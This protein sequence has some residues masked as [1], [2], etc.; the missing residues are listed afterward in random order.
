MELTHGAGVDKIV[1]ASVAQTPDPSMIVVPEA[2]LKPL[3]QEI[4]RLCTE[5]LAR[6]RVLPQES[7]LWQMLLKEKPEW[8]K[9]V[10]MNATHALFDLTMNDDGEVL[11]ADG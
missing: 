10:E 9:P 8:F 1:I 3:C 4:T 5:S 2:M 6:N 11:D 7:A